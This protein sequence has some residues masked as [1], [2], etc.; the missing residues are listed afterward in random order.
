MPVDYSR[1]RSLIVK[2]LTSDLIIA[3]FY[4]E[5]QRGSHQHY[6]HL[7]GRRITVTFHRSSDTFPPKTL[8]IIIDKQAKWQEEDL[9][10]LDLLY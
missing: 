7:D 5:R 3:G 6:R 9:K 4:L 2:E 1:L 8:K 10:R